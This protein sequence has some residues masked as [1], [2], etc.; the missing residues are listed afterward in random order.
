MKLPVLAFRYVAARGGVCCAPHHSLF[1]FILFLAVYS[2]YH[3]E[4]ITTACIKHPNSS[5]CRFK[6]VRLH[7]IMVHNIMRVT[8]A[9]K[10]C[11]K[12]FPRI[13]LQSRSS[14][15]FSQNR[16]FIGPC[17]VAALAIDKVGPTIFIWALPLGQDA[18]KVKSPWSIV[19]LSG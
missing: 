13:W 16:L 5:M 7:Y 4:H 8:M 19:L 17:P 6:V 3:F 10:E 18:K 2:V 1:Y 14:S 15:K 11:F 9:N 12:N